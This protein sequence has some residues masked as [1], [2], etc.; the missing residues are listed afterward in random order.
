MDCRQRKTVE[1]VT[2][3]FTDIHPHKL[4]AADSDRRPSDSFKSA[5]LRIKRPL[6]SVKDRIIEVVSKALVE[7]EEDI[8]V[9]VISKLLQAR[10]TASFVIGH[11]LHR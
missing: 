4:I 5:H 1:S 10:P 11:G 9:V 3:G 2:L 7:T 8:E 6:V